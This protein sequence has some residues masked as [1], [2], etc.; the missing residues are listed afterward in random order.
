MT[1]IFSVC[2]D[3]FVC[4]RP[5][6]QV[7]VPLLSSSRFTSWVVRQWCSCWSWIQT[8]ATSC[9]GLWTVVTQAP[10]AWRPGASGPSPMSFTT[11]T[12]LVTTWTLF[13]WFLQ[14]ELDA[15]FCRCLLSGITN[16]TLWCCWTWFC[17]RRLILPGT[18]MKWPC[19]CYRSEPVAHKGTTST[20]LS[21][22]IRTIF[23]LVAYCVVVVHPNLTDPGTQA[24]PLRPQTGDPENRW[25]PDPSLA[26]A[27]PLLRVLLPAVWG[28][29]ADV[30]R[31]DLAHLLRCASVQNV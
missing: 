2:K 14:T 22:I 10:A 19:S 24:L 6:S 26:S 3:V 15:F 12:V 1:S 28:A 7:T 16:S 13:V 4:K 5:L 11:G 27:T 25:H 9:F 21:H 31:A 8:R 20:H 23:T 29:G 30:P 17:S 18:S